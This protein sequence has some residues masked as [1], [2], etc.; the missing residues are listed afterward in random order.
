MSANSDQT[1][2]R[3]MASYS[4]ESQGQVISALHLYRALPRYESS[5]VGMQ[6]PDLGWE[7][8]CVAIRMNLDVHSLCAALWSPLLVRARVS[9]VEIHESL[10][11]DVA[12]LCRAFAELPEFRFVDQQSAKRGFYVVKEQADGFRKMLLA[13]AKDMRV[14]LLRFCERVVLLRHMEFVEV[15]QQR[16]LAKEC[17]ELYAPLANRLGISWLKNEFEDLSLRYLFPADFYP[18]V[19][20]LKATQK[21]R[22]LWVEEVKGELN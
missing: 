22:E 19:R 17:R 2:L 18:I 1:L 16:N 15:V 8:L 13:M 14:V 6:V 4:R 3:Q 10:G 20:E 21:E 5:I 9:L 7:T 11:E 12:F